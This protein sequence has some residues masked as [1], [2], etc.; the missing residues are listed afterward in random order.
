MEAL[1]KVTSVFVKKP[2]SHAFASFRKF[3]VILYFAAFLAKVISF[4]RF[5]KIK[6]CESEEGGGNRVG[7]PSLLKPFGIEVITEIF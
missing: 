4:T 6:R 3:S 1:K 5:S 2:T 7:L